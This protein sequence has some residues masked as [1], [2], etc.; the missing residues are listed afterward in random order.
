[1]S[2]LSLNSLK[3]F[4]VH[5]VSS[6]VYQIDQIMPILNGEHL[7]ERGVNFKINSKINFEC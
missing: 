3:F 6:V 4:R 5:L 1:M 2:Y 7:L